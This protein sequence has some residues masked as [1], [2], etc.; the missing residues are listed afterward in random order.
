MKDYKYP[1][2]SSSS[3]ASLNSV[4]L[5]YS[6]IKLFERLCLIPEIRAAKIYAPAQE[7]G[8]TI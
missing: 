5:D 4:G 3:D 1:K 8:F 2:N 7:K 6:V